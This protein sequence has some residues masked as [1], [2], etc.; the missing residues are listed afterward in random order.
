MYEF[1]RGTIVD[2]DKN[3]VVLECCG[4]G[5][6]I[7]VTENALSSCKINE[8]IKMF[9]HLAVKEDDM[10]LF[11][12]ANSQEKTMFYKLTD[13]SGIGNKTAVGILSGVSLH[14][15]ALSVVHKDISVLS[16]IKGVGKKTAERILL[17]LKDKITQDVEG[18]SSDFSIPKGSYAMQEAKLA[19][20]ALGFKN[21]EVDK[22]LQSF[23]A[24][25]LSTEQIIGL[26]LRAK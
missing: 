22:M 8:N 19:L 12:F 23:D 17:E 15:L 18:Q 16:K 26:A 13:I 11:G 2:I 10:S 21:S 5:Y 6:R 1:I 7:F 24:N 25:G 4:I 9:V 3:V 14:D 20:N